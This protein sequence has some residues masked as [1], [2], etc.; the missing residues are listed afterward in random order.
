MGSAKDTGRTLPRAD[1]TSEA[2][3]V[4]LLLLTPMVVFV[5]VVG[6]LQPFNA[7]VLVKFELLGLTSGTVVGISLGVVGFM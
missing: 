4:A 5:V 6:L 1:G 3:L 2:V 7:T